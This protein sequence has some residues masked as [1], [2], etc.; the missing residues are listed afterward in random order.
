MERVTMEIDLEERR[1]IE[2]FRKY[3]SFVDQQ[4]AAYDGKPYKELTQKKKG[5]IGKCGDDMEEAK[6]V[7]WAVLDDYREGD[8]PARDEDDWGW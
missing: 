7:M 3:K 5:V 2:A 6:D 8:Y 4:I 1:L